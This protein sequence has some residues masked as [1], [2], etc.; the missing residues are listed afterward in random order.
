M[1]FGDFAHCWGI[2]TPPLPTV[3]LASPPLKKEGRE[4]QDNKHVLTNITH[5]GFK[6]RIKSLFT[7]FLWFCGDK[8]ITVRVSV[9]ARRGIWKVFFVV[10]TCVIF[11][12]F[13]LLTFLEQT[14]SGVLGLPFEYGIG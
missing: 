1:L 10:Y 8:G 3:S 9:A 4:R 2:F 7:L 13:G 6:H 5:L 12:G 11:G 14:T